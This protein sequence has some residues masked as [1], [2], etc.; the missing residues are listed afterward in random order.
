[1][2]NA[3]ISESRDSSANKC[4]EHGSGAREIRKSR[5]CRCSSLKL[6]LEV[7][8]SNAGSEDDA[9]ISILVELT[10]LECCCPTNDTVSF[11]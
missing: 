3:D 5:R 10:D 4:D 6:E 9:D 7:V 2:I 1:M 8:G 11:L